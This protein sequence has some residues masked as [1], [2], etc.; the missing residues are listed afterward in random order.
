MN[1]QGVPDSRSAAGA[2]ALKAAGFAAPELSS[3]PRMTTSVSPRRNLLRAA[4]AKRYE[5][6]TT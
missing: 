1:A 5:N 6:P 3:K 4:L 2:L